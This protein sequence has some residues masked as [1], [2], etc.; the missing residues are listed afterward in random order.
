MAYANSTIYYWQGAPSTWDCGGDGFYMF[1]FEADVLK[2]DLNGDDR[3]T[4]ADAIIALQMVVRGEHSDAA[5]MDGDGRVSSV[6]ALMILQ[7]ASM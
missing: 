4:T 2:G 1:E 6:D 7:A 5:D 3:I